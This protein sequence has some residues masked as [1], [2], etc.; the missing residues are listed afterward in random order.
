MNTTLTTQAEGKVTVRV[1]SLPPNAPLTAEAV[2]TVETPMP[3]HPP[4]VN[5][6]ADTQAKVHQT[7]SLSASFTDEDI[8][9]IHTSTVDWGDTT[10]ISGGTV[11]ESNG[12]GT[13]SAA[14]AYTTEGTFTVTVC[15]TDNHNAQDCDM[16]KVTVGQALIDPFLCY[17]GKSTKGDLC[18]ADAPSNAGGVRWQEDDCG[19]TR[20][21]SQ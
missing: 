8:T 13:V 19:G 4:L 16:L 3:N 14:H 17:R 11:S 15:V 20:R 2:A 12:V 18:A 10:P 21:Q 5:A 6:G 9:D 7:V 1:T